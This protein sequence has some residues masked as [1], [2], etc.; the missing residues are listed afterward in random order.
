METNGINDI[1]KGEA[2]DIDYLKEKVK[3]LKSPEEMSKFRK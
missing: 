3:I 2:I 1:L